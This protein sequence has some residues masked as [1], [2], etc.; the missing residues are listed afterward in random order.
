[1]K[2]GELVDFTW[3]LANRGGHH[4]WPFMMAL[5]RGFFEE[6]GIN[7]R[8]QTV[9]GGDALA[10]AMG[11]GEIQLGRMGTPPFLT[12][13]GKGA[14][15]AKVVASSVI[16]NL[17]HFFFVVRP[18]IEELTQ[19][20]GRAVGV[21]SCGSCDGHLMRLELRR[22]GLDPDRDVTYRELWADYGK[23]ERLASGELAAQLLVEPQ[24]SLGELRGILRVV[25]PVSRAEPRFQWGLLV[26]RTDF[27]AEQPDLLRRLLRAYLRGAAYCV[28]HPEDTKVLVGA[29]SPEYDSR[30]IELAMTRTLAQWNVTGEVDIPGL[31]IAI[32]TMVSLGAVH[33]RL[34]AATLVD[35][36][37]LPA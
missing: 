8:L 20:R 15:S 23:I 10:E 17:Q 37:A 35:T 18:E 29:C 22:A 21:L 31:T 27:V 5:S 16:G 30:V 14:L 33:Q 32:E 19:L 9:P 2:T 24:V 11:R 4:D 7:L 1:M 13:V 36:R 28:A 3:G 25:E 12:A 6:E 26:A 34:D